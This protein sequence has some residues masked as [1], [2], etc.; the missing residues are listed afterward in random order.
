MTMRCSLLTAFILIVASM[1]TL[2]TA[3]DS[4]VEGKLVAFLGEPELNI[5]PV[6][7]G[8]RFPNVV[9]TMKGTILATWG[10]PHIR[11]KRSED[12]GKTWGGDITIA[13]SGIHGGRRSIARVDAF[14]R[15]TP[16]CRPSFHRPSCRRHECP[17]W[18][19]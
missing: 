8:G 13:K 10:R 7:Q 6:F 4:S 18:Q 16:E 1:T 9:V 5:Q 2:L 17:T 14:P 19:W 12:G 11:A 3:A 15:R